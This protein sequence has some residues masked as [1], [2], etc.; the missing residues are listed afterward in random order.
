MDIVFIVLIIIALISLGVFIY[1][2]NKKSSA[3]D[4]Y[5][6]KFED[7]LIREKEAEAAKEEQKWDF[8]FEYEII[9]NAKDESS[10]FQYYQNALSEGKRQ[11]FT[12]VII[13]PSD[14]ITEMIEINLE[15]NENGVEDILTKAHEINPKTILDD[16]LRE[17]MPASADREELVGIYTASEITQRT[18]H[19]IIDFNT[20]RPYEELIIAKIPTAKPWEAAAWIP[21]GGYNECPSP[22]EQVA[23]F[24]YWHG[25][26]GAMPAVVSY[27]IWEMYVENPIDNE[28]DAKDLAWDQFAF[29]SDIVFQ[30]IG[31][32]NK[33]A[34]TLVNSNIW[35]FW[36]D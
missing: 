1:I 28:E 13:V 14:T 21:M 5:K 15:E 27:D 24:Q 33:L 29:C 2:N 6:I 35:F 20:K 32:I 4:L 7:T 30:G 8:P 31:Q 23:V 18:F 9:K 34:G 12:P 25:K 22:E 36:W 10:V 26:Y 3:P 11:G 16:R 19:S 17:L